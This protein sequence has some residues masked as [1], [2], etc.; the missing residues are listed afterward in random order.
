MGNIRRKK[1]ANK[2]RILRKL[3]HYK[4]LARAIIL[5]YYTKRNSKTR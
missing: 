4:K 1:L 2:R 3:N 5:K